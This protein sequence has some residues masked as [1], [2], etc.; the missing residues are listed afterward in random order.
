MGTEGSPKACLSSWQAVLAGGGDTLG[1]Q[2]QEH[3]SAHDTQPHDLT[4]CAKQSLIIHILQALFQARISPL[5]SALAIK[6][7]AAFHVGH[8]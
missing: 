4:P 8:K 7:S 2:P 3:K 5:P 6:I 1:C